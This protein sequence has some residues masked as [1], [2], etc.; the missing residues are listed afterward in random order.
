M[1]RIQLWATKNISFQ[2]RARLINNVIFGMYTYWS[3]IFLLHNE[4]TEKITKICRNYL[5]SGTGDSR[6]YPISHGSKLAYLNHKV[7]LA[8]RI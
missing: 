2:W 4:V 5:W 3:S 1:E 6:K 7:G 8:S